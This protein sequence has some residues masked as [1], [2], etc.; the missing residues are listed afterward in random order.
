MESV[1]SV[2]QRRYHADF[3]VICVDEAMKQLVKETLT[4]IGAKP[5]RAQRQD[6]QYERN[7]TAN[8]FMVC[9][10]FS[11]W[12]SVEVTERRT[13]VDYAHLLRHIVDE[14][15]SDALLITIVQDNLNIHHPASLYKAFE[16][17]EARRILEKLEF[18]YTPKHGSWLNMAEIE[19]SVLSGQCLDR[20]IGEF[21]TL[22]TEVSAWVEQRNQ[23]QTWI[24]WR[25]TTADAR[26]KLKH[27]YPS[28]NA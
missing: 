28:I 27:L 5:G 12:R 10:P 20:R 13:A 22:R 17:Q 2:Y 7:G 8:L 23:E 1:L 16:P 26:L 6:Y 9:E 25:F 3:P 18:C 14:L 15:F 4:P 11:G 19:L 21:E 24:D